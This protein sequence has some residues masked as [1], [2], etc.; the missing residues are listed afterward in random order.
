[1]TISA[2]E[3]FVGEGGKCHLQEGLPAVKGVAMVSNINI[4][5]PFDVSCRARYKCQKHLYS[6]MRSLPGF[7]GSQTRAKHPAVVVVI[8]T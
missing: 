7:P 4:R 1:M 2:V 6:S 3:G 8:S 5:T